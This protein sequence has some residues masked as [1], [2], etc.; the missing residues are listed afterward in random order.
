MNQLRLSLLCLFTA[1]LSPANPLIAQDASSLLERGASYAE[2]QQWEQAEQIAAQLVR[3]YPAFAGGYVLRSRVNE[4]R[5]LNDRVLTDLGIA[6]NLEPDNSEFRFRYAL[7]AYQTGRTDIARS[8]FRALL[9]QK[10]TTTSTVFYRQSPGG[11]TDRIFTQQSGIEDQLLHY[12]GLIEIKS[13]NYRR[14][15]ELLDSAVRLNNQ[16]ADLVAHRGL[17]RERSGDAAGAAADFRRAFQL[18]PGQATVLQEL[19]SKAE[20]EGN[21][22]DAEHHLTKAISLH[23]RLSDLYGQ[24]GYLRYRQQKFQLA[25]Q[26]YDSAL[27]LDPTDAATVLN[28][29]LALEKIGLPESAFRDFQEGLRMAPEWPRSW[30]LLGCHQLRKGAAEEAAALLTKAIQLDPGYGAAYLNRGIA[31]LRSGNTLQACS[32]LESAARSG[33]AVPE[34]LMKKACKPR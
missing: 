26:D 11:G 10:A 8:E 15:A 34:D 31:H 22:A 9:R 5:R 28:R 18:Q 16:D 27:L 24:R 12:L 20:A 14:A 30:F 6:T 21:L 17:A 3:Q 2:K 23:P 7:A 1:L 33:M 13:G 32:D 19:S 29:G 25:V 4:H